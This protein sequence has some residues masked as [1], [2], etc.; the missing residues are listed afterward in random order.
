MCSGYSPWLKCFW[1]GP[2]KGDTVLHHSRSTPGK[3]GWK[4]HGQEMPT[5]SHPVLSPSTMP[6]RMSNTS[7]V[8]YKI[9]T[10]IFI[11]E[12]GEIYINSWLLRLLVSLYILRLLP[13]NLTGK[14]C[15][16][17]NHRMLHIKGFSEWEISLMQW[18]FHT[19]RKMGQRTSE[20]AN[21]PHGTSPMLLKPFKNKGGE[22]FS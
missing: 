17:M 16:Q 1:T 4:G 7:M 12:K 5:H 6:L 13:W 11:L 19:S 21:L 2:L 22:L 15:T 10:F 20:I 3:W 8:I 14:F 18:E 9:H